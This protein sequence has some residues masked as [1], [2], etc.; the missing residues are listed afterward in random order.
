DEEDEEED[1]TEEENDDDTLFLYSIS[2]RQL[3]SSTLLND[4]KD[5]FYWVTP[6]GW[7]L[8]L[9]RG[10]RQT[11]LWD[12]YTQQRISLP[13][14]QDN[15]LAKSMTRCLLSH[16]PGTTTDSTSRSCVVVLV[17]D[18]NATVLWHKYQSTMLAE[19]HHD[20]V[21][22]NMR[23]LTAVGDKFCSCLIGIPGFVDYVVTLEFS[24]YP[25]VR[26]TLAVERK[27]SYFYDYV[28]HRLLESCGELFIVRFY[29][30][31]R[32][33]KVVH[34]DV[35]RLD[36]AER[37]WV[38][39]ETL[40]GRVFF[41]DSAY[42]GASLSAEEAGLKGNCIYF[43]RCDDKGLYV[44]DMERGTTAIHNPGLDLLDDVTPV[45]V[46]PLSCILITGHSSC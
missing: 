18:L 46:M 14:D 15:F 2:R 5:H 19:D 16:K 11:F 36:M 10:S 34:I 44:Y 38:K 35:H 43:L 33:D 8:M 42:S 3:Q 28:G 30:P 12:L 23:F 25:T 26:R 13:S 9:H 37:A 4:L 29:H 21:I 22:I 7:L 39:V 45:I 41:L 31:C 24:P 27:S 1:A 32:Q 40:G 20:N 17:V 6:Q